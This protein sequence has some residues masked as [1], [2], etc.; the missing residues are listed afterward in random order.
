MDDD[1]QV[2]AGTL[3]FVSDVMQ[4]FGLGSVRSVE[5]LGGTATQKWAVTT[6]SGRV[7]VR[8]RPP[9]F[10]HPEKARFDHTVLL[11]L[12][13][14]GVP[15]PRPLATPAGETLLVRGGDAVEVL[16]WIEGEPWSAEVPGV[17]Q[18]VGAFLARFHLALADQR[19][20]G[21]T[22]Q[23]REDHPDEL[24][25]ILDTL[26]AGTVD[27]AD[28][29]RLGLIID[30]LDKG[31]ADLEA[32]LYPSLPQT[33]IHGDFHPGNVRF[34]GAE[35]AALYDF[36]YLAVQARARDVIDALMFFASNRAAPFVPDD[37][38]SLTQTFV[39]DFSAS[40]AVLDGYRSISPLTDDE[41]RALPLLMRSRWVQMRLR[42][43]RKVPPSEQTDFVLRN[44]S[45][46]PDWIQDSGPAF[47]SRLRKN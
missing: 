12:V 36:D 46:V 32:T 11:R 25:P 8:I 19:P 5:A 10:A 33:V 20:V 29:R 31:R 27:P 26:M 47:F 1:S 24:Q 17:A 23:P 37:I 35:V 28:R 40:R 41:W 7:V 3:S 14:A 39:P 2:A 22:D 6:S 15:V 4:D 16:S 21:E 38:H 34:C 18:S 45:T 9:E 13:A 43:S 30:L 44:F 42:G